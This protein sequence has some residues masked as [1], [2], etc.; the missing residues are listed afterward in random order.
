MRAGNENERIGH[1][2][3]CLQEWRSFVMV[4]NALRADS[5]DHPRR[6]AA[7]HGRT[8]LRPRDRRKPH[9]PHCQTPTRG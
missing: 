1:G 7:R 3:G 4:A 9:K 5:I 8:A 6:K 2:A